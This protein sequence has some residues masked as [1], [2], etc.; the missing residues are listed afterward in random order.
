ME[1]FEAFR[2]VISSSINLSFLKS[3]FIFIIFSIDSV[4]GEITP[5]GVIDY[6]NIIP[7]QDGNHIFNLSVRAFDLGTPPLFR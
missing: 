3:D 5:N 1:N 4:T 6:E 7:D 2:W